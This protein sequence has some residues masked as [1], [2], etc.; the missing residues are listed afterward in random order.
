VAVG[1]PHHLNPVRAD[2]VKKPERW[3]WSSARAHLAGRD[4]RLVK[5]APLLERPVFSWRDSLLR[6]VA[7]AEV[8]VLR[9]HGR[10]GRPLGTPAFVAGLEQQ[11]SRHLHPQKAGRKPAK[12]RK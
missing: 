9:R 1:A 3:A 6:P 4:D 7:K 12:E 5:V 8:E 11:L 2:L 10:T